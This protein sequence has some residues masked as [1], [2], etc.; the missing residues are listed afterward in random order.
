MEKTNVISTVF[1][2][3]RESKYIRTIIPHQVAKRVP[4]LKR[5]AKL[6]WFIVDDKTLAAKV[7]WEPK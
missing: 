7:V 1:T 2:S 3:D 5:G 4:S 6:E